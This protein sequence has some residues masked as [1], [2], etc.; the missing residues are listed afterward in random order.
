MSLDSQ[1]RK[2]NLVVDVPN[3]M[4]LEEVL[5]NVK[6]FSINNTE[7][8]YYIVH[9]KDINDMGVKKTLHI[10]WLFI[11][12]ERTR[13]KT[14]LS[15][16]NDYLFGGKDK[17]RSL[18]TIEIW[19]D[20]EG[21]IQ[22]L[23]HK[24]DEDKYQYKVSDIVTNEKETLI[25]ILEY[26]GNV[27][28]SIDRIKYLCWTY[29]SLIDVLSNIGLVASRN[30]LNVIKTIWQECEID[31]INHKNR[32]YVSKGKEKEEKLPFDD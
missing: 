7:E 2:F 23:V 18:I 19:K 25:Q 28:L 29:N 13:L 24:N 32:G 27:N 17:T 6:T 26:T 3:N 11:T 16:V 22:Y 4:T 31:K 9:D 14:K 12:S 5:T 30:Y 20:Y 1:T 15:E 10:H 8:Y 21:A